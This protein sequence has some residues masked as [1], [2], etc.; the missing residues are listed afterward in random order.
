MIYS[1]INLNKQSA[2]IISITTRALVNIPGRCHVITRPRRS[3]RTA[4]WSIL[5]NTVLGKKDGKLRSLPDAWPLAGTIVNFTKS[6]THIMS[7]GAMSKHMLLVNFKD[8]IVCMWTY[9][10]SEWLQE[11][12]SR[13]GEIPTRWA[14]GQQC[15]SRR[16]LHSDVVFFP[17]S[18]SYTTVRLCIMQLASTHSIL[19]LS[20]LQSG[21]EHW[22]RES[23]A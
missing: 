23:G 20:T 22:F 10:D 18:L 13:Q 6:A 4:G 3:R 17:G 19:V 14:V 12:L 8:R 7:H 9:M 21:G 1:S 11:S 15:R 2:D 5:P 16:F